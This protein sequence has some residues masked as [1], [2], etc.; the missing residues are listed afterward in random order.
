ML[1]E[2]PRLLNLDEPNSA[3]NERESDRLFAVPRELSASGVTMLYVSHRLQE[4][5][6]V[7]DDV[8]VMRNGRDTLTRERSRLTI[9]E[10]VAAITCVP[11]RALYPDRRTP[12][13]GSIAR[14]R[15]P[16][17]LGGQRTA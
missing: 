2:Q 13:A 8:T 10:V 3:L 17:P 1:L 5:F 4:V 11:E 16:G 14:A 7:C 6:T 12:G 9:S 15:H